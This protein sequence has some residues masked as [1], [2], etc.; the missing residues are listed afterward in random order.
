MLTAVPKL[1]TFRWNLSFGMRNEEKVTHTQIRRAWGLRNQCKTVLVQNLHHVEGSV[2][3]NVV[4][5]QNQRVHMY[6]STV[7]ILGVLVIQIQHTTAYSDCYLSIKTHDNLLFSHIIW[8]EVQILI[9]WGSSSTISR[10]TK[11]LYVTK[12]PVLSI[13]K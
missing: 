2:T 13:Y 11:M 5:T 12:K 9:E 6:N 3:G 8:F 10:Q 1:R 4:V 7:K